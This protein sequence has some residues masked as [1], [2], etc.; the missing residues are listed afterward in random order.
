VNFNPYLDLQLLEKDFGT[1]TNVRGNTMVAVARQLNPVTVDNSGLCGFQNDKGFRWNTG[2]VL[3]NTNNADDWTNGGVMRQNAATIGAANSNSMNQWSIVFG[4]RAIAS[5]TNTADLLFTGGY[6][7]PSQRSCPLGTD[8]A[9]LIVFNDSKSD[10][11]SQGRVESYLAI[12]YGITLNGGA[13]VNSAGGNIYTPGV[14]FNNIAGIGK[15]AVSFLNQRQS[16]SSNPDSCITV[17]LDGQ[18]AAT[19]SANTAGFASDLSYMVW[20]DDNADDCWSNAEISIPGLE[21]RYWR[22]KREWKYQIS[23]TVNSVVLRVD[24]VAGNFSLPALPNGVGAYRFLIDNDGDFSSGAISLP[25]TRVNGSAA[26]EINLSGA[27]LVSNSYFTFGVEL[28]ISYYDQGYCTSDIMTIIGNDLNAA[29]LCVQLLGGGPPINL[30]NG[31]S[32]TASTFLITTN[33]APGCLDVA[34]FAL[35]AVPAGIYTVNPIIGPGCAGPIQD[36]IGQGTINV[37]ATAATNSLDV[38]G[39]KSAYLCLGDPNATLTGTQGT[40]TL[41]VLSGSGTISTLLDSNYIDLLNPVDVLVH[42]GNTGHYRIYLSAGGCGIPDSVDIYIGTPV[43]STVSYTPSS[44]CGQSGAVAL[45]STSPSA[46]TFFS[47]PGLSLDGNTGGIT[48]NGSTPGTYFVTFNPDDATC[49]LNSTTSFVV[50]ND[51]VT[52]FDFQPGYCLNSPNPFPSITTL[53]PGSFSINPSL[54]ISVSATTGEV[55]LQPNTP[56]GTYTVSFVATGACSDTTTD[57]FSLYAPPAVD[58]QIDSAACDLQG[59]L[60]ATNMVPIGF[61]G[62]YSWSSPVPGAIVFASPGVVDLTLSS[63]GGPHPVQAAYT[64]NTTGCIGYAT[65]ELTVI[66][67]LP[68]TVTYPGSTFCQ[69]AQNPVPQFQSGPTGGW[70]SSYS[71]FSTDTIIFANQN[72]G[73][74][75]VAST[76]AGTYTVVYHPPFAACIG[77]TPVATIQV[78]ST[79][80]AD[81]SMDSVVCRSDSAIAIVIAQAGSANI[82]F[83]EG[84]IGVP[85]SS[86]FLAPTGDS[87]RFTSPFNSL[88]SNQTYMVRRIRNQG[89][90]RDTAYDFFRILPIEDPTFDFIQSLYCQS[91]TDPVPFIHGTGG[92]T[93]SSPNPSVVV[94]DTTGLVDMDLTGPGGPFT[95][96]YHTNGPCPD[97]AFDAIEIKPGYKSYFRYQLSEVCSNRG[98]LSVDTADTNLTVFPDPQRYFQVSGSPLSV[99]AVTGLITM[100]PTTLT[101]LYRIAHE[102][103]TAPGTCVDTSYAEVTITAPDPGFLIDYPADTVCQR[104]LFT[105]LLV[106]D[107]SSVTLTNPVGVTYSNRGIRGEVN[108]D[109]CIPGYEYVVVMTNLSVCADISADS[110]YVRPL[111]DPGFSYGFTDACTGDASISPDTINFSPGQFYYQIRFPGTTLSINPNTGV[112]DITQSTVNTSFDVFHRTLGACPDTALQYLEINQSPVIQELRANNGTSFCIGQAVSFNCLGQGDVN[113]YINGA[114]YPFTSPVYPFGSDSTGLSNGDT[115]MAILTTPAT[116]CGDSA[117]LVVEV[118][119]PPRAQIVDKPAVITSS[120]EFTLNLQVLDDQTAI[121]WYADGLN[122]IIGV[123]QDTTRLLIIGDLEPV[124]NSVQVELALNPGYFLFTMVPV[125]NGCVGETTVDTILVTEPGLPIFIPEVMTPDG[126]GKNDNW[127]IR[128]DSQLSPTDYTIEVYSRAGARVKTITDLDEKWFGDAN[129]DGVYWWILRDLTGAKLQQGGLTIRRR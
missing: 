128:Y 107:T 1:S 43:P 80:V 96:Q 81:F 91:A 120:E 129:P 11:G 2:N 60:A 98:T 79:P 124:L 93:F 75:D 121:R 74:I 115:L 62:A 94:D 20:G 29:N 71:S 92:G 16:N 97:T 87:I 38:N 70:F 48:P 46:G 45:P 52:V 118:L 28:P 17:G 65:H 36:L 7:H 18:I 39:S 111:D 8:F 101:G 51:V 54:N 82:T 122:A 90:C 12:K 125:T 4:T 19:N 117:Y 63:P 26:W 108:L 6:F 34:Q 37:S 126:N 83:Y 57:I 99:D 102:T 27:N 68:V 10:A 113:W 50:T 110:F 41:T 61:A 114:L 22:V 49:G 14:Y 42:S 104:G 66:D 64:D 24:S 53:V 33:G 109:F 84:T 85:F 105:P 31:G 59:T 13:Y 47:S 35:T 77:S 100:T 89:V 9:E 106:G 119:P 73:E 21:R 30:S 25:M 103:G 123:P 5:G 78:S 32:M 3:R 56:A 95:I 55:F 44:V 76:A 112:I 127:E 40:L 58:F 23:G 86:S 67:V 15:D 69:T 88:E 72:S 116:G